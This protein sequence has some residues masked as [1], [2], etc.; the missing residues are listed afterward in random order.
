MKKN[1]Q[2]YFLFTSRRSG[3]PP[4][5]A[6]DRRVCSP[7]KGRT[8]PGNQKLR[9]E[10][11]PTIRRPKWILHPRNKLPIWRTPKKKKHGKCAALKG[12]KSIK[13]HITRIRTHT[14]C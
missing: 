7:N 6:T 12:K 9:V 5:G 10:S 1:A 3:S 8:K 2:F 4:K 14:K 11:N 13:Q